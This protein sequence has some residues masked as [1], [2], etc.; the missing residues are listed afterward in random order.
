MVVAEEYVGNNERYCKTGNDPY[1]P[2]IKPLSYDWTALKTTID[3]MQPT[4][5][6]NQGIGMAWAWL[7]LGVGVPPFN[8]PPK[9]T[10]NYTYKDAIIL[11][12]DG[13]NTENRYSTRSSQIDARQKILCANAK[14]GNIE[15]YTVQVN[16]GGDAESAVLKECAS[17]PNKFYHIKDAGQTASVFNSIGQS[18]AKL[19]VAK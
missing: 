6:T 7:T 2:P 8:A 13:L 19:R 1:M 3:S 18:L 4:G 10:A 5:N 11:L 12:S 16:T 15:V 14:A 17:A 9:D